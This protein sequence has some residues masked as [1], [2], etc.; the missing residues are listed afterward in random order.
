MH[1]A[2]SFYKKTIVLQ[3][4]FRSNFYLFYLIVDHL[5]NFNYKRFSVQNDLLFLNI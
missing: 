1:T 2:K 3:K 4:Y 5:E